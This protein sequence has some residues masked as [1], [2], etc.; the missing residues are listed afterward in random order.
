MIKDVVGEE[1][2]EGEEMWSTA[3]G[4]IKHNTGVAEDT[5]RVRESRFPL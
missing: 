3:T 5:S 2:E 1:R 4:K